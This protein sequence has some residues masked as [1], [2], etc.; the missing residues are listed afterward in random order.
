MENKEIAQNLRLLGQILELLGENSFKVKAYEQAYRLIRSLDQPLMGQSREALLGHKGIGAAIADKILE[1]SQTGQMQALERAKAQ[2]S[3]GLVELLQVPGLG[4]SKLRQLW[5]DLE[6]NSVGELVYA[7]EENRLLSLKGFGEKTQAKLLE[8]LRFVQ[9]QAGWYRRADLEAQVQALLAQVQALAPTLNYQVTGDYR[10]LMPLLQQVE[11]LVEGEQAAFLALM[12]HL[13]AQAL[14]EQTW[15]WTLDNGLPCLLHYSPPAQRVWRL[16]QTTGPA[17]YVQALGQRLPAEAENQTWASEAALAQAAQW[18]YLEPELRDDPRA[19][20]GQA[21]PSDLVCLADIRGIVHAHSTY[22]DGSASLAEMAKAVAAQGW[23]Y[24]AIT[25]HSQ[26]A[27]YANGLKPERVQA[28]WAEIE[29]LNAA[30]PSFR[31]FKGIEA[32]ILPSGELD[33]EPSLREGFELIIASVHSQLNMSPEKA[34]ERLLKAVRN[35]HTRILGHPTGR[36][37]G[38][39][40]GYTPDMPT[41]LAAC[42]EQG[43]AVE[44]N[45]HPYRL[46]LDYTWLPLAQQLGLKISINPDAHSIQGLEVLRYGVEMA[47]KGWLRRCELFEL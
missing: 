15:R 6:I 24:L 19:L 46:D 25:D 17:A 16:W 21:P 10:R 38:A 5:Q 2:V 37:L 39:R 34:T 32:D 47:R 45:A 18:P 28:Q 29:A 36:L 9:A 35:P 31:I 27:F 20:Q 43:V 30:N 26:A 41:V 42:A 3:P 14:D 33:Y 44:L 1:L 4:P 13:E 11:V 22:S 40:P 8:Q 23:T 7:C 12:Q